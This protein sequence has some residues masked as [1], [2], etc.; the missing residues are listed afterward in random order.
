MI[1]VIRMSALPDDVYIDVRAEFSDDVP[2]RELYNYVKQ[3]AL[4]LMESMRD[5]EY[6]R[7]LIDMGSQEEGLPHAS[8]YV[9]DRIE[10]QV[11]ATYQD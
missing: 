4:V 6:G 2:L 11:F 1:S 3:Y 8:V 9:D 10:H 7:M 5:R